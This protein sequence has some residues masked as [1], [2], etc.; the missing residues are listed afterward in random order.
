MGPK[1]AESC[2]ATL[3]RDFDRTIAYLAI[4]EA[5]LRR[6]EVWKTECLRATSVLERVQRHFRQK[7]RQVV[8]FHA[9]AG[10]DAAISLVAAHHHLSDPTKQSWVR[11]LEEALLAA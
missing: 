10:V 4:Q 11:R 7:A 1:L 6:G 3:E 5:A 2:R 8:I 9:D